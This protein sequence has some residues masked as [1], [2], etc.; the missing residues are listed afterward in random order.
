MHK[1]SAVKVCV[2]SYDNN[3][4]KTLEMFFMLIDSQLQKL[5]II[6]N[7]APIKRFNTLYQSES[8]RNKESL[9]IL[10]AHANAISNELIKPGFFSC[11]RRSLVL[12]PSLLFLKH[13]GDVQT[14]DDDSLQHI[15]RKLPRIILSD[16]NEE[17]THENSI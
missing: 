12:T 7:K 1:Y 13:L 3:P 6:D 9:T 5:L 17:S 15:Q 4:Q 16:I 14:I 10:I 2:K 8:A 11:F